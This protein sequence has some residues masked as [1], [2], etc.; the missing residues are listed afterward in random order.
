M[1]PGLNA[2]L[3]GDVA[4]TWRERAGVSGVPVAPSSRKGTALLVFL[5]MQR[6]GARREMLAELLWGVGKLAS[7]R[8]ALYEIRKLPGAS[9]WLVDDGD[10]VRL[11]VDS[12]VERFERALEAGDAEGAVEAYVGPLLGTSPDLVTPA[13]RDWWEGERARLESGFVLALRAEVERLVGAERWD[14]AAGPLG[15]WLDLDPFEEAAHRAAIR[16]AYAAGDLDAAREAFRRCDDTLRREFG[17]GPSEATRALMGAIERSAPTERPAA[18]RVLTPAQMRLVQV[19]EVA[20]GVLGIEELSGVLERSSFDVATDLEGL[21]RAGLLD[22]H[23]RVAPA[24]RD[25]VRASMTEATRRLLHGRTASRLCAREAAGGGSEVDDG[26]IG[27]H[28][29][30]AGKPAEAAPRF[31]A[32]ARSEVE[33]ADLDAATAWCFRALWALPDVASTRLDACL[34]LE[35]LASQRGAA[36]L[37]DDALLEAERLAWEMQADRSLAEVRMRRSRQR[38]R[39]G[40]V[41]DGL[42]LALEALEIALRLA[43]GALVARARNAVG[44]AHYFAGD[45]E[46][47]ATAFGQNV[48]AEDAVERYRARNNLGSLAAIRG[49]VEE[50]YDHFEAALTLARASGQQVDTAATL[51]NLAA[52]ADRLG[53][54]RRAVKHFRE[55]IALAR[56]NAAPEREGQLLAN[57]AA[58]YARQGQFGPAWNTAV[59]VEEMAAERDDRRLRM[60]ALEHQ[61]EV[62]RSCGDERRAVEI[63]A[64]AEGIAGDLEDD[65]K[66]LALQAQLATIRVVAGEGA[67]T[68]A[69]AAIERLAEARLTDIA[70]WLWLEHALAAR[71]AP[72]AERCFGHL[73]RAGLGAHQ[74]FVLDV[75]LARASLLDGA[76]PAAHDTAEQARQRLQAGLARGAE[77]AAYAERPLARI[78]LFAHAYAEPGVRIDVA[79]DVPADVPADVAADVSAGVVSDVLADVVAELQEQADG[80][81]RPLRASLLALPNRWLRSLGGPWADLP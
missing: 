81:P 60:H 51:N 27:R 58:V 79:A 66:R 78:V 39:Q 17:T 23:L 22:A 26:V 8:Q 18:L 2:R 9:A 68:E 47:A 74:R 12:D 36:G 62:A 49:R 13:Y 59:E 63:L 56:R 1:P 28:L 50:A 25:A 30:A 48:D 42:E 43:D 52:T 40:K 11:S 7:V 71:T 69:E 34:L 65:R 80:L 21:E 61:A 37:Q 75:A 77:G 15:R 24:H 31:V 41:G 64:E 55:G 54:Y 10:V 46:G 67:M 32:A 76:D 35:G 57:L 73:D 70:P 19:L 38:L 4:F 33:R 20:G 6:D 5:A 45:L 72:E 29:L 3:L 44:A 53:D 14:E 16:V